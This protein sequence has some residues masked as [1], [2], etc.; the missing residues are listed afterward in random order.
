MEEGRGSVHGASER[1]VSGDATG[2][3]PAL[4]EVAKRAFDVVI[5][6]LALLCS[7]PA[8]ILIALAVKLEDGGPVFYG[9]ERV[10]KGGERFCS[11]KFRSMR[12]EG[13]SDEGPEQQATAD[14][15]RIT[16]V[17]RF[18]RATALDELPQ[19]WS[20]FRGDMSFVGPRP[21]LPE[22]TE[23]RGDGEPVRLSEFPGYEERHSVRP[24]LTGLAQVAVARDVPHEE[25]F[26]WDLRYVRNR[27]FGLDLKI[28]LHSL[29]ITLRGGWGDVGRDRAEA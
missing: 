19:L 25:K 28:F 14:D 22:E 11:W 5:S 18:L 17:G 1:G 2:R 15:P 24:G 9:H 26:R 12:P 13:E 8:W 29:W 4:Y 21:L 20:I 27:S 3:D 16:R 10:G 6:G 7:A 23:A